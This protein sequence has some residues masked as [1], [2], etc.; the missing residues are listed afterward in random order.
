MRTYNKLLGFN[1]SGVRISPSYL[2]D[3]GVF[4]CPSNRK[5]KKSPYSA[6]TS[7][8]HYSYAMAFRYTGRW[9]SLNEHCMSIFPTYVLLVD[10]QRP[11]IFFTTWEKYYRWGAG[12]SIGGSGERTCLELTPD[13]NHGIDG[14]NA[15][16]FNGSANWIPSYRKLVDGVIYYLIPTTS[17]FRGIPNW[18]NC[19]FN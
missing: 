9:Q 12:D 10:K 7:L 6:L 16:F 11:E 17:D 5:H 15:L 13:N 4:V 19:I 1:K 3:T 2:K 18:N 14:V 8:N